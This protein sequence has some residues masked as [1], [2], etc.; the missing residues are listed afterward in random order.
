MASFSL[1]R[2]KWRHSHQLLKVQSLPALGKYSF[3]GSI[4]QLIFFPFHSFSFSIIFPY[5]PHNN[6]CL[7]LF[8]SSLFFALHSWGKPWKVSWGLRP[9]TKFYS[10]FFLKLESKGS[11]IVSPSLCANKRGIWH[12]VISHTQ[13]DSP[14]W[15]QL[16]PHHY[17]HRRHS[18]QDKTRCVALHLPHRWTAAS[19]SCKTLQQSN[20]YM[21]K[22]VN[23]GENIEISIK[24]RISGINWLRSLQCSS[25]LHGMIKHT[26]YG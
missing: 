24:L 15:H 1:S 20:I 5:S 10:S 17:L 4:T 25:L 23:E 21:R 11:H 14:P 19:Y 8:Y 6:Y 12:F 18:I 7:S 26:T 13:P 3:C 2:H 22:S 16:Y 9:Q